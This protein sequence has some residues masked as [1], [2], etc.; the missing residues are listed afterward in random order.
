MRWSLHA[1]AVAAAL[2]LAVPANAAGVDPAQATPVQREQAQARFMRGKD[3]QAQKKYEEALKEYRASHEIVASPNT[4]LAIGRLL[5]EMGRIVEA[6]N[7]LGRTAIEGKELAGVDQRYAKAGES[8]AQERAELEPKLGFVTVTVQNAKE[9]TK[10]KVNGEEIRRAAWTEPAPV[11]PGTAE[12]SVETPG[13]SP[14]KKTVTLKAGEK[15]QLT[16]DAAEGGGAPSPPV[17]EPE[18]AIEPPPKSD[19]TGLRPIAYAAGGVGV[20]GLATFA[21]FGLM[22]KSTYDDLKSTC[23]DAPCPE[24]R[25]D[26]VSSGKTQQT[27][28]NIGLVVGAVG[29]AAGVTL[30]VLSTP[31]KSGAAAARVEV[32]PSFI[33]MRGR[34]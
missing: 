2:T 21:V 19:S 15:T 14:V 17:K 3:L 12:V 6:Y 7:E 32:G 27:I 18:K 28:A 25:R 4:R 34:F 30:F 8:A 24:D 16:I 1:A 5:R 26:D 13:G 31:S 33:G 23:G 22:S 11:Q 9:D 20:L 29:L 10:L